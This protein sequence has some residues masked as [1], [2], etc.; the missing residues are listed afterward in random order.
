MWAAEAKARIDIPVEYKGRHN[1]QAEIINAGDTITITRGKT[2]DY[3]LWHH[4]GI[5]ELPF[6]YVGEIT[7][8]I[9]EF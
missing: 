6:D 2:P 9:S 8:V 4:T 5:Y 1:T 3:H 7:K